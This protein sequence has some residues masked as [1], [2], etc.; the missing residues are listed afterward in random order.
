MRV[1]QVNPWQR[2]TEDWPGIPVEFADLGSLHRHGE[3]HWRDGQPL[4]VVLHGQLTQVQRR[5][6]LAHELEHLDR[7]APCETLRASIE[8]RI[9][10]ATAKYL[11]PDLD[12]LAA[13]IGVYD[14]RR[15]ADEM[16]VT[17]PIMVERLRGLTDTEL[18]YVTERR[19]EAIA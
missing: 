8:A 7:G 5:C 1:M 9:V 14:L 12:A 17:F 16:W 3:T 10:R 4:R 18:D 11:L 15:A 19:G 13:T 6:T 2:L